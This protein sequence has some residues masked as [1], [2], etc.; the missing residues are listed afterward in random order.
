MSLTSGTLVG[1]ILSATRRTSQYL[2]NHRT[3]WLSVDSAALY[4][5][6][7]TDVLRRRPAF[8]RRRAQVPPLQIVWGMVMPRW[9][10]ARMITQDDM[11]AMVHLPA[12]ISSWSTTEDWARCFD[13]NGAADETHD[14]MY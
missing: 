3:T 11:A 5:D 1:F 10:A 9:R 8:G 14:A 7:N 12:A 6:E 4:S 13:H 2:I